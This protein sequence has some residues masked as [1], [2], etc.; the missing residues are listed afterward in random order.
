MAQEKQ[1]IKEMEAKIEEIEEIIKKYGY[2]STD[3]KYKGLRLK[4]H[5][6]GLTVNNDGTRSMR[7]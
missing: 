5:I 7:W 4:N 2:G 1:F 6:F 3:P